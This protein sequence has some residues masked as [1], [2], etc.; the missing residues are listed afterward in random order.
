MSPRVPNRYY[1]GGRETSDTKGGEC[2]EDKTSVLTHWDAHRRQ[3][4][5]TY[6][7]SL[8]H[9]CVLILELRGRAQRSKRRMDTE[10]RAT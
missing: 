9:L 3:V 5:T 6:A 10:G 2:E 7:D 1:E 4:G 8:Q